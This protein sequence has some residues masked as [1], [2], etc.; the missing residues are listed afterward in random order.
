[1]PYAVAVDIGG[2]FTDLVAYDHDSRHGRLRQEPDH[3]RQFRRGHPRLLRA[4]R[5]SSR[6]AANFVNHGTTLVI[7]SLIQR[8]GAKAALVT[9]K[10]FRDV[11]EIARGN[12]PDPFDLHYRRDEP[13]DPARAA[14]RGDGAHRQQG[15]DRHAARR[16]GARRRSPPSSRSS[17]IEAVAIF[18][19]NSYANPAHEEKAAEMLR[20]LLPGVYVTYSTEVTREWYEYER[21]STVAAN[22]YVGPQVNTLHPPARERPRN[23]RASPARCS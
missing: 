2:T 14:L 17:E 23:A 13:L 3:L 21:T 1:M 19:M 4:R 11:L 8:K 15:R 20:A 6:S 10:G 16:R 18:F 5:S 9:T 22:A 12:R 7:N